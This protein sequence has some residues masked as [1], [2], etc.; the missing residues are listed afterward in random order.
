MEDFCKY[1]RKHEAK[2]TVTSS[3]NKMQNKAVRGDVVQFYVKSKGWYHSTIVTAGKKEH[4]NIV[5]IRI[6]EE[7]INIF[8]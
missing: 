4:R 5:H 1:W 3:L 8:Y 2:I 6:Q 7:I